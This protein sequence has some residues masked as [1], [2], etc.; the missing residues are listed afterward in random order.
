MR[1]RIEMVL[2][3]CLFSSIAGSTRI[4]GQWSQNGNAVCIETG[5]QEY[6]RIIS[7][8]AG[9]AIIAWCDSRGSD[10]DI[11]AERIGA[12]GNILWNTGGVEICIADGNQLKPQLIPDGA[13][14][15]IIIWSD[16]RGSE[17]DIY[18]QRVNANGRTLWADNGLAVCLAN[19]SQ[20][21][22]QIIPEGNG[23]AIISWDDPRS[24]SY[25]A[26][27]AQRIDTTGAMHWAAN[28]IL[29]CSSV[30]NQY[31]PQIAVDGEGGIVI[32]WRDLRAGNNDVYAQ[33]I[34]TLGN[35]Q[36][37]AECVAVCS[38]TGD[39][40]FPIITADGAGG[41]IIAW[42][43]YRTG[44]ADIYAQRIDASG[45]AQWT[46]N[47]I[48]IC[49][50]AGKDQYIYG[51]V[52]DG[53]GGAIISLEDRRSDNFD[54]YA[55]RVDTNGNTVW[56]ED[57]VAICTATGHQYDPETIPD[58]EGGAFITWCDSRS[59]N[60][61]IYA[62]KI[63]SNG[64][65]I[66]AS[67]GIAL[68]TLAQMQRGP[69]IASDGY[70][71]AIITWRD[72]RNTNYD[73]Y[74]S[75][76]DVYGNVPPNA[77]SLQ[78]FAAY[79]KGP[80]ITLEWALTES[81]YEM[82]FLV[83]RSE[84]ADG[85]FKEFPSADIEGEGLSF[86]FR[87]GSCEPGTTYRYRVD[88]LDEEGR[89]VLFETGLLSTPAIPL[90]LYQNHPNPFNPSTTIRYYL[91]EGGRVEMEI[92]DISGRR[93]ACMVSGNQQRGFHSVEWRGKDERGVS[94]VSGVYF[95]RLS[96]GKERVTRK[97]ILLK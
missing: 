12:E 37:T 22:L 40:Q 45:S 89:R 28:G 88:V 29:L 13:G 91:P 60:F 56:T 96:A 11:Y 43:D 19:G 87:D 15:A 54:I 14:G 33:R 50:I 26:I 36:W 85:L 42:T 82:H 94:V 69:L 38:E 97:M 27:Y 77:T 57:G 16:F 1:R 76:V 6:P 95:Y 34:D 10:F 52:T 8:G 83:L 3:V 25:R 78:S 53:T 90:T 72:S 68:C 31:A 79:L 48:G 21:S 73:I 66:W 67:N 46:P 80:D 58:D 86:T 23:K 84:G 81:G 62:Q 30:G 65:V 20:G 32:T 17:Y 18:A 7:D 75:K 24:G 5:A 4:N 41:T 39:Q 59:G 2:I 35:I 93:V 64:N 51:I 70:G 61:D 47:G 49:T 9:G 92:F 71:G 74:A 63:D 44:I 55:Q